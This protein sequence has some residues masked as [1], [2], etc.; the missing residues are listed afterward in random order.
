MRLRLSTVNDET[1]CR[2][3]CADYLVAST[4]RTSGDRTVFIT[5]IYTVVYRNS[6][7]VDTDDYIDGLDT[8]VA[9]DGT[10]TESDRENIANVPFRP[11]DDDIALSI[12]NEPYGSIAPFPSDAIALMQMLTACRRVYWRS[13]IFDPV[14]LRDYA[15]FISQNATWSIHTE[16]FA[17]SAWLLDLDLFVTRKQAVW[18]IAQTLA[19]RGIGDAPRD[20]LALPFADVTPE[21]IE[22][23][24]RYVQHH[25]PYVAILNKTGYTEFNLFSVGYEIY[26]LVRP[27][28]K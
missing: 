11:S 15:I 27:F 21:T 19:E 2:C 23:I 17:P 26:A 24:Y 6:L 3:V 25:L 14:A 22:C 5:A 13:A 7:D 20:M 12:T 8:Y 1:K 18:A 9:D 10:C 28:W 16:R 4:T